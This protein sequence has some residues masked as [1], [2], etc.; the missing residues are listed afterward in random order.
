VH[1]DDDDDDDDDASGTSIKQTNES[2]LQRS[3]IV[4]LK[5]NKA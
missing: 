2:L 1:D 3:Q 5:T 4:A